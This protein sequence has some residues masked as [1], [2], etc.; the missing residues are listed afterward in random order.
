ML[1][2]QYARPVW[3]FFFILGNWFCSTQLH[4]PYVLGTWKM[5]KTCGLL[6]IINMWERFRNSTSWCHFTS[7]L[8][9]SVYY[10]YPYIGQLHDQTCSI[11][12]RRPLGRGFDSCPKS[13]VCFVNHFKIYLPLLVNTDHTGS[14]TKCILCNV[15]WN[16][17]CAQLD[18]IT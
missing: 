4:T 15:M 8:D 10:W 14:S 1:C 2:W 17:I 7:M 5:W 6:V 13:E 18:F 3:S 11:V 9:C 12:R 16:N